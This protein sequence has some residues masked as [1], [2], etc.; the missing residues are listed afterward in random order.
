MH[1]VTEKPATSSSFSERLKTISLQ[2][3]LFT[4]GTGAADE[5]ETQE[6]EKDDD[7]QN[8]IESQISL[9]SLTHQNNAYTNRETSSTGRFGVVRTKTSWQM[10]RTSQEIS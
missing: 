9:N 3:F 2:F 8:D 1:G 7:E 5:A 4:I 6:E 10:R